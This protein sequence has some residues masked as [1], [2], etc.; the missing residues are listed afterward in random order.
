MIETRWG[1]LSGCELEMMYQTADHTY[2]SVYSNQMDE[3]IF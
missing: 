3:L 1:G 2:S